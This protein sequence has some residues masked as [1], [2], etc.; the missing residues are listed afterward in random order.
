MHDESVN[1]E[2]GTEI[3]SERGSEG[4]RE[5][6]IV[7]VTRETLICSLKREKVGASLKRGGG[8]DSDVNVGDARF[9]VTGTVKSVFSRQD[10]VEPGTRFKDHVLGETW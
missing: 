8:E 5:V 6:L 1:R 7:I 2:R 9:D 4:A 3:F 10:E